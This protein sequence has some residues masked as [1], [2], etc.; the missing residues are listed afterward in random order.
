M[1]SGWVE[2]TLSAISGQFPCRN[3]QSTQLWG[4][5][6]CISSAFPVQFGDCRTRSDSQRH[7]PASEINARVT[8]SFNEFKLDVDLSESE[9]IGGD[10]ETMMAPLEC[11]VQSP[12]LFV[13][14]VVKALDNKPFD[15]IIIIISEHNNFFPHLASLPL[16]C[17]LL[18]LLLLLL[19]PGL[20]SVE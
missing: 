1:G 16:P 19:H 18:L 6:Q 4:H 11:N 8:A 20:V 2:C 3:G 14:A 13:T 9:G 17:L 10:R 5:F 15:G 12:A 7:V